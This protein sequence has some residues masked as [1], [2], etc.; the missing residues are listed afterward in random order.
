VVDRARLA[1][2]R[3]IVPVQVDVLAALRER[4][5]PVAPTADL[6]P[7]T[8]LEAITTGIA[9]TPVVEEV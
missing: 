3:L 6:R 1:R 8:V 4:G 9:R 7:T 2:L 5:A